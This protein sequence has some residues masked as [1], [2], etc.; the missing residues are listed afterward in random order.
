MN[1]FFSKYFSQ[2]HIAAIETIGLKSTSNKFCKKSY[3][4]Y[5]AMLGYPKYGTA[6]LACDVFNSQN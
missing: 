6:K 3:R 2:T 5:K 1:N 4:L